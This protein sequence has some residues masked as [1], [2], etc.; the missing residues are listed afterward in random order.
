MGSRE[1]VGWL[2][3]RP[4]DRQPT[5]QMSSSTDNNSKLSNSTDPQPAQHDEHSSSSRKPKKKLNR[6]LASCSGCRKRRTRCDRGRPC[7]ECYKRN[8]T[9]DYAGASAPPAIPHSSL[10]EQIQREEYIKKL[11]A[12][13]QALEKS[14]IAHSPTPAAPQDFTV[15][16]LAAQLSLITIGQRA[17]CQNHPLRTQ[18]ESILA[19]QSNAPTINFLQP[20][21]QFSLDLLARHSIPTLEELC[22]DCLPPRS[23]IDFLSE[24]FFN[25]LNL[26][27]PAINPIDWKIQLDSFW[28]SKNRINFRPT[29][30]PNN[31]PLAL[32]QH[33]LAQFVSILYGIIG[34]G[35]T[36]LAD[37]HNLE[38]H[39]TENQSSNDSNAAS[40]PPRD[41][42][43]WNLNQAE[44][45]SLS[46]RWFRFSLGLL[47]SPQG[48][49]YTKPTVFG[50][51]AMAVLS[52]VEHAPENLDHGIFFWSLTSSLTLAAGL[53]R[54]PPITDDEEIESLDETE[55]ESRR[56]LSWSILSLDW[57]VYS[58]GAGH[59]IADAVKPCGDPDQ[60][61][62]KLP[63]TVISP[64]TPLHPI[65][66]WPLDPLVC[67]RRIAATS[68]RLMRKAS[69]RITSGRLATYQ[70]VVEALRGLDEVQESIPKRLQARI[71]ADGKSVET[72]EKSDPMFT[73]MASF[74]YSRFCI[75]RIRL[76][77]IFI[78]PKHGVSSEERR[79]QLEMLLTVSK[80]HFLAGRNYP[81][82]LSMH[83]LILYGL[84][85][86][87]VAC[88]LV[89]L[90]NH[91]SHELVIEEDFFL[92]EL[93]KVIALF[94]LGKK[95]IA[96]TMAR[97]AITLLETLVKQ[98]E[99]R[100]NG[101]S[102]SWDRR[103]KGP[104]AVINVL[105]NSRTVDVESEVIK[106]KQQPKL[107]AKPYEPANLQYLAYKSGIP[108]TDT[109]QTAQHNR[110][111]SGHTANYSIG[112][113]HSLISTPPGMMPLPTSTTVGHHHSGVNSTEPFSGQPTPPLVSSQPV[114]RPGFS[115]RSSSSHFSPAHHYPSLDQLTSSPSFRPLATL[116]RYHHLGSTVEFGTIDAKL[117]NYQFDFSTLQSSPYGYVKSSSGGGG[118][119]LGNSRG[120]EGRVHSENQSSNLLD[121]F[122][123]SY[124][125]QLPDLTAPSKENPSSQPLSEQLTI[126]SSN[127][128]AFQPTFNLDFGLIADGI[129]STNEIPNPA[130][131]QGFPFMPHSHPRNP[132][133][134]NQFN[135]VG[136]QDLNNNRK[137]DFIPTPLPHPPP[138]HQQQQ[139]Q[140]STYPPHLTTPTDHHNQQHRQQPDHQQPHQLNHP[141][142]QH[143]GS[144]HD[145]SRRNSYNRN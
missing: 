51:R 106:H 95:T 26:W 99:L 81:H 47:M 105:P 20:D 74:V 71:S 5:L 136:Y 129:L 85:N 119:Q 110:Q 1:V 139:R 16:D 54:E 61:A 25:T 111:E 115:T 21:Q 88:A 63:G 12:R 38:S 124:L 48:S 65:D 79:Q 118:V 10:A 19:S 116:P 76:L 43:L 24:Y 121:I 66:G 101:G 94:D 56:Q 114:Q 80:Q 52:N 35:L 44:K 108:P 23:Q 98:I 117:D 39:T 46:N 93:H 128:D 3:C 90:T 57:W 143:I 102:K 78:F 103:K 41:Y 104:A 89:L 137:D 123:P 84:I 58:L 42:H 2:L 112:S 22:T 28:T 135:L 55:I 138:A 32:T 31:T 86:T 15:D 30:S 133:N 49:I 36:R 82:S 125:F 96:A 8:L 144:A 130:D 59:A 107:P 45:I 53:F 87:S 13:L 68:D 34:H 11:E 7:S 97:K 126:N 14:P 145:P 113:S 100:S 83:P 6:Q 109:S 70:D 127:L 17:R 75:P 141:S 134:L 72:V 9:C 91:Q 33:Y 27:S 142:H 50:I 122:D 69:I 37:I 60:I 18:L 4:E 77:R 131:Q 120:D 67:V 92:S 64:A 73:L 140:Y 132:T 29:P 62:V 40:S